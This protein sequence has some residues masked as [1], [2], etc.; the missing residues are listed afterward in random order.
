MEAMQADPIQ[1]D[2]VL[3]RDCAL[4]GLRVG[5][6]EPSFFVCGEEVVRGS[7]AAAPHLALMPGWHLLHERCFLHGEPD[8][9]LGLGTGADA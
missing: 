6:Y 2:P 5:A 7:R 3:T 1:T 8:P 9:T 4:C